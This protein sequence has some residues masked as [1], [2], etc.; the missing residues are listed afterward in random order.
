[1]VYG[2]F[3]KDLKEKSVKELETLRIKKQKDLSSAR[4]KSRIKRDYEQEQALDIQVDTI[5]KEIV[6]RKNND[7]F[8]KRD[9]KLTKELR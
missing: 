6:T 9:K 7:F 5:T 3:R 8:E 1:M 4:S 2:N